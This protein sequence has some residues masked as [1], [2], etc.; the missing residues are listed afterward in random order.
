[1]ARETQPARAAT[2]TATAVGL[3]LLAAL[4]GAG[5]LWLMERP[6]MRVAVMPTLQHAA[7][8]TETAVPP[9][10]Q[11]FQTIL[12]DI[13]AEAIGRGIAP[14]VI[15]AAFQGLEP[16]PEVL[17]LAGAQPEHSKTAG[18]YVA[19]LASDARLD[20][21]RQKLAQHDATLRAIEAAFGVDR[22]V[23][24]AIWGIESNYGGSMGSRRIVRSLATL[25]AFDKRRPGF[26]R[27]ELLAALR[28]LH[29]G[30]TTPSNMAGSWAG[31][32]GHTQFM[33]TTYA[34]HAVD[35]DKDGRR[36][37]WTS[38]QDALASTAN[39]LG[40]SGWVAGSPW[41]FEAVL[42][43]GFDFALAA[44]GTTKSL[45]AWQE[46]GVVRAVQHPLPD[47]VGPLHLL[48]PAGARG[49]AFLVST[50]FNA[51]LRYNNALSYAIAVG[52][53]AD[54]LSGGAPLQTPWPA[55]D[56]ALS[57]GDREEL[58]RRLTALGFA[59]GGVDGVIGAGTKAA[60]RLF[61]QARG[62]PVDGHAGLALLERLR[63]EGN[64]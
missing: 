39:Y 23:V 43:A 18:E 28:I 36:D 52:H 35:F 6:S 32:M 3:V 48:L 45:A 33:P 2:S 4:S 1:M 7:P 49:P 46:L 22:H 63:Q 47:N 60:A 13:R 15:D 57:L 25:A 44:P 9:S 62:V 19:L 37:I 17:E 61:Q 64:K 14:A 10:T 51:I 56:R 50:N 30:D 54:R 59:T 16:D 12:A 27:V 41:G 24:V 40:A 26:W 42:P 53:L 29:S 34:A 31:A 38:I 5:V 58:Q 20:A 11:P 55:E 8:A 21:G